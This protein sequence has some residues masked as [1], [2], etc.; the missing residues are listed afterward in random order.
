MWFLTED[1]LYRETNNSC[2]VTYTKYM[3]NVILQND[4]LMN[5]LRAAVDRVV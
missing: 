3:F 2:I 5:K 4:Y 1:G